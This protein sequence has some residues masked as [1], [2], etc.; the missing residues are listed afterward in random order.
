MVNPECSN[1]TYV[2]Q[3]PW[4][5]VENWQKSDWNS[6]SA[7][8]RGATAVL[9]DNRNWDLLRPDLHKHLSLLMSI[10]SEMCFV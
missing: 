9:L 6:R 4:I 10:K 7:D 1:K 5:V 3:S 2:P 8:H